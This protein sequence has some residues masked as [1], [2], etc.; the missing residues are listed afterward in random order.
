MINSVKQ[1]ITD[2]LA[3]LYPATNDYIIYDEDI[4]QN[5]RKPSFL[6]SLTNQDYRKRLSNK[7]VCLLSFDIAYFS[8]KGVTEIKNDCLSVQLNLL[9]EVDLIGTYRILNKQAQIIDNVLHLTFDIRYSEIK[10]EPITAMQTQE[11][12]TSI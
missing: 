11:T 4:P 2:K 8:K 12:N 9:R 5:F 1:A 7:S 10:A 3:E 6:I